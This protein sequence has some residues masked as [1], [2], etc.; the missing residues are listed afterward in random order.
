[1]V[2]YNGRSAGSPLLPDGAS[3]SRSSIMGLERG[4]GGGG[5]RRPADGGGGAARRGGME[6]VESCWGLPGSRR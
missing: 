5:G 2:Q 4:G 6:V 3:W 1:V